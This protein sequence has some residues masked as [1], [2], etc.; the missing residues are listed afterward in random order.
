MSGYR[1]SYTR[2]EEMEILKYIIDHEAYYRLRGRAVWREMQ[3][4]GVGRERTH[5][6]L[7]EHFKKSMA[8]RL[9]QNFYDIDE[10]KLFLIKQGYMATS[11]SKGSNNPT[12]SVSSR[13]AKQN[14]SS[15]TV[16]VKNETVSDN[17]SG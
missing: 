1:R 7:K 15:V 9:S 16:E 5:E 2:S 10:K 13:S 12:P 14:S 3:E 17:D 8:G 11:V 4:A 6:S